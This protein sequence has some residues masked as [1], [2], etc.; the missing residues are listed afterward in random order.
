MSQEADHNPG[1][2]IRPPF[3]YLGALLMGLSLDRLAGFPAWAGDR[4]WSRVLAG[5]LIGSAGVALAGWAIRHFR[6]AGTNVPTNRPVHAL[7]TSGPYRYTRNPIYVGL[8]LLYCGIA[9]AF[10]SV[11]A[12]VFLAVVLATMEIGVV[13]REERYLEKL[14]GNEYLAYRRNVRRWF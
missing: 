11:M 9:V 6:A 7:V 1:V 2:V 4:L 10:G 3:L 5:V 8:T 12:F 13:R 14:F